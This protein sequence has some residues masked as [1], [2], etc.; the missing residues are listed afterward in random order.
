MR[1]DAKLGIEWGRDVLETFAGRHYHG[2]P[3]PLTVEADAIRKDLLSDLMHEA[4]ACGEDVAQLLER[5]TVQYH[6][7]R[8]REEGRPRIEIEIDT[9]VAD[10]DGDVALALLGVAHEIM[11][12]RTGGTVSLHGG[13]AGTFSTHYA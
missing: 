4:E 11:E 1:G 10:N 2:E 3:N 13:A 5:A 9:T 12:G 7:E 6:A 8:E